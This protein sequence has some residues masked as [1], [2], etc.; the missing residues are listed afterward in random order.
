MKLLFWNTENKDLTEEI[1]ELIVYE[2]VDIAAFCESSN[3]AA[4]EIINKLQQIHNKQYIFQETPG[5]DRI[6]VIVKAQL[7]NISLLTQHTYFSLV[8]LERKDNPLILGFVH[9]P[10]LAYHTPEQIRRAAQ[11]LNERVQQ[12]ERLHEINDSLIIGDFNV[13]P[14]ETPMIEFSGMGAINSSDALRREHV[15][16]GGETKRLFFNPMWTL[17]S[18]YRERPGSHK[19]ARLGV[20]VIHWHF[21]DQVIIRPSL[22]SRFKFDEL[23]II[24][25]TKSFK[26]RGRYGTPKTSDHLPITCRLE[27]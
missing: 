19:Y 2:D 8:K 6:K 27:F 1:L 18:K 20:D 15:T 23:K 12:E 25:E 5:C 16:D 14:F 10:S 26:L 13:N 21:L 4:E 3:A 24:D 7:G 11:T 17:Y 22:I 9:L